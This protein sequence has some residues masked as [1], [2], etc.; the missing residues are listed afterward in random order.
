MDAD[1]R[2]L[3]EIS[4]VIIGCSFDVSNELGTGFLE[5][6]Y[7]NS[8][9]TELTLRGAKA[10]QQKRIV[11][12]YKQVV[13]GEY[14]ADLVVEGSVLVE[15]KHCDGIC[16]AHVAQVINYLKA[17]GFKLCLIINFGKPKVEIKRVVRQL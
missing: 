5:K 12:R 9:L 2:R 1:E 4:S 3:N 7:E 16:D 10:E 11:V 17:T 15:V 8:L 13:V 14:I 6:V